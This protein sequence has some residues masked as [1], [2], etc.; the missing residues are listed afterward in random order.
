MGTLG[1]NVGING[2]STIQYSDYKYVVYGL[3]LI[4]IMLLRPSGLLPSRARKVELETGAESEPLA[5]VRETA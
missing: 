1:G 4:G 2:L 5:S 3:I